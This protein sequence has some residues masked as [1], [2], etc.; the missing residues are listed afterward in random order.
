MILKSLVAHRL[1]GGQEISTAASAGGVEKS[2]TSEIITSPRVA[3]DRFAPARAAGT[4]VARRGVRR[5]WSD[6]RGRVRRTS[7]GDE[8][9]TERPLRGP[10]D[11]VRDVPGGRHLLGRTSSDGVRERIMP[12][13]LQQVSS[14]LRRWCAGGHGHVHAA[15]GPRQYRLEHTRACGQGVSTDSVVS[16]PYTMSPWGCGPSRGT[17]VPPVAKR[18]PRSLPNQQRTLCCAVGRY[19]NVRP[20]LLRDAAA[21]GREFGLI[22]G[23][24]A[25]PAEWHAASS[26]SSSPRTGVGVNLLLVIACSGACER[27]RTRRSAAGRRRE[28][29][30]LCRF[31][32]ADAVVLPSQPGLRDGSLGNVDVVPASPVYRPSGFSLCTRRSAGSGARDIRGIRP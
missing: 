30:A 21:D 27:A 29:D 17:H 8:A 9:V 25:V 5:S 2:P 4:V 11:P 6:R 31:A 1:G 13:G 14:S 20:V 22:A 16:H 24:S 3:H 26:D 7:W 32:R 10:G 23:A 12:P 15:R 19:D 18:H 28:Q